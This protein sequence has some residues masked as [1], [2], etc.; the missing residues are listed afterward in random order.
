MLSESGTDS[1]LGPRACQFIFLV[2]RFLNCKVGAMI[3]QK[4][5]YEKDKK[6]EE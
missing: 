1:L 2:L 3:P 5:K 4:I 6:H